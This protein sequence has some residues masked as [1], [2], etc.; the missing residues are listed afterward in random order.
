[1]AGE[2][3]RLIRIV[4]KEHVLD[5]PE[6]LE[7]YSR[8]QGFV[9][10][11]KPWFVVEPESAAEVQKIVKWANET[12]TPLVPVSS[13]PPR[14]RGDTVPSRPGS[15]IVDLSRMNRIIRIDRR[16]RMIIIEPGVTYRQLQPAL[17]R[18]DL[19]LSTPLLPRPA[20]SVIASLLEREPTLVPRYNWS[21]PEPLRCLE[22]VW[23]NGEML[24]T[25]E[26]G[27]YGS[28]ESQWELGLAQVNSTGP[29][30]V[31][32]YRLM[33]AAQGTLG[34]ATWAS[35]KCEVLPKVHR[36]FF[37]P[38][39]RL[40]GLIDCAYRLLRLRLGDEFLLLNSSNLA[41]I[42]GGGASQ[43]RALREELPP[44][45]III[46]VAGRAKLPEER[47][48]YQEN[49]IRDIAQQ[50]GLKLAS[51][52]P[53]A[54][55]RAVLEAVLNPSPEPYWK[56]NCKGGCQDIFFLTTLNR[57]PE[58]LRT[59]YSVAADLRYPTPEIG[60]YLQPQHQGTVCHCEFSLPF[61]REDSRET[62]RTRELL[63]RASEALIEQGA[64]FSRP[65]GI[66]ADMV[67]RRDAGAAGIL[68]K[69]KE[70]FDPN[71]V[72]N[73]GKLCF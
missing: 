33:S 12:Q 37:I 1:M 35:I 73:P 14:F 68:K 67:Y 25:G 15:V 8:D 18:E 40:E 50:F 6:I 63:S 13:G 10:P 47:V 2:K 51:A 11:M 42:L 27:Q 71:G 30:Q 36:L 70:M 22:V 20:K 5:A 57:T 19:R 31:D 48:E 58:F 17:A 62:A 46:G 54:G 16:N 34:I 44:W 66:W 3:E 29:G 53:G 26:A 49:D 28:L 23:G 21:M 60:V 65:Y 24:R 4:G 41:A 72:L 38:S 55:E 45:V 61:N 9:R 69:L 39:P 59:M 64:F 43:T 52:V 7:A 56:L 32:Y